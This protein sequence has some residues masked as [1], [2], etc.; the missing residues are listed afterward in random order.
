MGEKPILFSTTMVQAILDGRKTQTRRIV[1]VNIADRFVLDDSGNV[2]GSYTEG[3]P[4]VYPTIDDA[5][6]QEGDI[7]WVRETW[8]YSPKW[9]YCYKADT[10]PDDSHGYIGS[11][12]WR[13][14]IFMPRAA[15][16]LFLLVKNVWVER[17][18]EIS[19]FEAQCE[20]VAMASDDDLKEYGYRAGFKQL[21]DSLNKTRGYPWDSNPWVWIYEF[22]RT[23]V[24]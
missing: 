18:Q 23:E 1:K 22:E 15:A 24:L 4:E 10:I 2:L 13:P 9:Y 20:G 3:M 5:P 8:N 12:P 6:Y 14:S 17:L 16:R 19:H 11:I 21:W 7:L